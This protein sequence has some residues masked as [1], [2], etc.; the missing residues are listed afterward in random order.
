MPHLYRSE[1]SGIARLVRSSGLLGQDRGAGAEERAVVWR[2]GTAAAASRFPPYLAAR[3]LWSDRI[4]KQQP[5]AASCAIPPL[6]SAAPRVRTASDAYSTRLERRRAVLPSQREARAPGSR[7][8]QVS[9]PVPQ[10]G[11]LR[12]HGAAAPASAQAPRCA[13]ARPMASASSHTFE[14]Q[15]LRGSQA[16][17]I[18]AQLLVSGGMLIFRAA[19][20]AYQQALVSAPSPPAAVPA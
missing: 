14:Q 13:G 16:Q 11:P 20:Q 2:P 8:A 5:S 1:K 4:V 7:S 3:R 19:A 6:T 9:A 17:K 18:I 12:D 10:A 15:R